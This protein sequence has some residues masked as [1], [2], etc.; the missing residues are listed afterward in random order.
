M[1][2]S[3]RLA[4]MG[5]RTRGIVGL[6][7]VAGTLLAGVPAHAAGGVPLE[8]GHYRLAYQSATASSM[9]PRDDGTYSGTTLHVFRNDDGTQVCVE[10]VQYDAANT[11]IA[12]Y[13]CAPIADTAFTVDKKLASASL[14]PTVVTV[15]QVH[16][17]QVSEHEATCNVVGSR[18]VTVAA[19]FAGVGDVQTS[20]AHSS[21][22]DGTYTY[23]FKGSGSFRPASSSF[24]VDG[25][26][27]SGT[28]SLST[29]KNL[30][31]VR[32]N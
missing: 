16:C 7:A 30:T 2:H 18:E 10:Q 3:T 20:K 22:T 12:E 14:A 11:L 26:A 9:A 27:Q 29:S 21:Y 13:G 4:R 17:E 19:T 25:E 1:A 32:A 23:R 15:S 6:V 24:T 5:R 31:V 8:P 28:G